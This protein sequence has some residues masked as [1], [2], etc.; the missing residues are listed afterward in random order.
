MVSGRAVAAL[1][2]E[3]LLAQG[4]RA[5]LERPVLSLPTRSDGIRRP[6]RTRR[7]SCAAIA[8]R[9]ECPR[10]MYSRPTRMRSITCWRERKLPV[11]VDALHSKTRRSPRAG[12]SGAA[13]RE[14][15]RRAGGLRAAAR[16][17]AEGAPWQ[18]GPL[19]LAPRALLSDS[20]RFA[21]RLSPAARFAA[22]GE[23]GATFRTCI[24]RTRPRTFAALPRASGM[25]A[26]GAA[27]RSRVRGFGATPAEVVR[28]SICAQERGGVLYVFM[29]PTRSLDDYLEIV[30][31]VEAAAKAIGQPVD[32]RRLRAARGSAAR[33]F[34]GDAGPRRHRGQRATER[35]LG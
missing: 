29:P 1:V 12:A 7:A 11:N 19:V 2:A 14:R 28:T 3:L 31:A 16:P 35:E 26:P 33:Q 32:H 34:Q 23:A 6:R 10:T 9:W 5:A 4:R 17:P 8:R 22:L 27:P 18:S 21:A 25:L 24:R 30:A 15:A 20:G 13:L